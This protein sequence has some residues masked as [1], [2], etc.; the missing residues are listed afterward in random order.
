MRHSIRSNT[1]FLILATI[2]SGY[3]SADSTV[4]PFTVNEHNNI[5]VKATL[6]GAD[7]FDLMLHTASSD[8]TLTE[9]AVTA[10][11]SIVFTDTHSVKS[12]GGESDSRVSV[13]NRMTIGSLSRDNIIVWEDKNSGTAT[14]GKFGLDFFQS[15]MVEID[16]ARNIILTHE[17]LP[18]KAQQWHRLDLDTS[19]D[20]LLFVEAELTI[21][22][23]PYKHRFLVHSGYSGGL[24]LDDEFSARTRL[25]EKIDITETSS[26]KDSFGNNIEVH[27]GTLPVLGLG[28]TS[29]QDVPTGF[30]AGSVGTQKMSVMGMDVLRHFNMIFDLQ[31]RALY[32]SHRTH[33]YS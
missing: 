7:S 32:I 18:A 25:R 12:W 24:L 19:N 21:A 28:A 17:N 4:V 2:I 27:K 29:L 5:V 26:L 13:G 15:R 22:G 10:S 14:D 3:A 20:D 8:V 1:V 23:R 9:D 30:F 31:G 33:P 6:N 16:F 11:S